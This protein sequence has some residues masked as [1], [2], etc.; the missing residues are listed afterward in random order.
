LNELDKPLEQGTKPAAAAE[1]ALI[2]TNPIFLEKRHQRV[3]DVKV[4]YRDIGRGEPV[5]FLHGLAGAHSW[6]G[7]VQRVATTRRAIVV[8]SLGYGDSEGSDLRDFQLAAQAAQVRGL[9]SALEISAA[10][11]VGNDTGSIVAQL[12]AVRWPLCAKSLILSNYDSER[13]VPMSSRLAS[14]LRYPGAA[15]AIFGSMNVPFI[16]GSRLGPARMFHDRRLLTKDRLALYTNTLA[17]NRERRIR[18]RKFFRSL[19]QTDLSNLNNQVKELDVPTMIVWGAEDG[20]RSASW[21]KELYDTLQC[22]RRLE[23]IPFAGL[24]CHE[25]RP[26]TFAQLLDGFLD[27]ITTTNVAYLDSLPP[28]PAI[29]SRLTKEVV[30]AL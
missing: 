11:I 22:A 18:L 23:L 17:G 20:Y 19:M 4:V 14:F 15:A 1:F 3:G 8:E 27:E 12:F 7:V 24:S 6:D 21:A 28:L 2:R 30:Q 26:D 13:V 25:E 5:V 9:L 29:K 16:A 10:H